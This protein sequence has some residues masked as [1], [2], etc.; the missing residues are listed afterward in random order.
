MSTDSLALHVARIAVPRLDLDDANI[1]IDAITARGHEF[2]APGTLGTL[3][4]EE[5]FR[6][7]AKYLRSETKLSFA[8]AF[9]AID[10]ITKLGFKIREPKASTSAP[11]ESE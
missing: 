4:S 5:A 6:N 7:L 2:V 10:A 3:E 11:T 8:A 1:V 9:G